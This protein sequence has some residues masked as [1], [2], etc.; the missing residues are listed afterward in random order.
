M[1]EW[2]VVQM[3]KNWN[4]RDWFWLTGALIFIIILLLANYY[5]D[6]KTDFSIIASA[7]SIALAIMAIFLSLKQDSDS[8]STSESM[9]QDLT[10][11]IGSI[12][13]LLSSRKGEIEEA[14]TNVEQSVDT[15]T[16]IRNESY[17]Y[18]QLVEYGE[19][20]K[21]ETIDKFKK[22]LNDKMLEEIINLESKKSFKNEDYERYLNRFFENEVLKILTDY[23]YYNRTEIGKELN[24]RGIAVRTTQFNEI[25]DRYGRNV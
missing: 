2:E 19:K 23:P 3:F 15:N 24:K 17:T 6:W 10:T 12:V 21:Q 14:A 11:Q 18:E 4:N 9:R 25:L 16:E 5:L 20:I 7:T 1:I 13:T 22:E 8:K